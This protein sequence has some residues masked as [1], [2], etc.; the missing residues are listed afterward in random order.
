MTGWKF[1]GPRYEQ[2]FET[3]G[4]KSDKYTYVG[5]NNPDDLA[6]A[7]VSEQQTRE[8]F[9]QYPDGNGGELANKREKRNPF[10]IRIPYDTSELF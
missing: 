2:H 6:A 5:V 1:K 9:T 4:I 7:E 8:Q 10:N 3:L